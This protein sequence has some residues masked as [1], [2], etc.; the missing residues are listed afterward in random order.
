VGESRAGVVSK[1]HGFSR[2]PRYRREAPYLTAVGLS[3]GEASATDWSLK[4]RLI[5]LYLPIGYVGSQFVS[6]HHTGCHNSTRFPSGS[7][8]QPKL[9]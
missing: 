9:P 1:G 3:A 7:V 4:A 2:A 5:G 8:N 6:A